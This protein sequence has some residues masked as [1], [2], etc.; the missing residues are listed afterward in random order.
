MR[1]DWREQ[2]AWNIGMNLHFKLRQYN[3]WNRNEHQI[4]IYF[5]PETFKPFSRAVPIRES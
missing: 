4:H 1:A 2:H 5:Y 3:N